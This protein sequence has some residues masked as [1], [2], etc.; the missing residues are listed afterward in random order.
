MAS[1]D[2]K[3][4]NGTDDML[5]SSTS[6]SID[7]S[8]MPMH[9]YP[10][11]STSQTVRLKRMQVKVAC[12]NCQKSCKKCDQARPCLRCVKYGF[13]PGECVDS[14]RKERKK[15]TK[16]GPYKK[17]DGQGNIIAQSKDPSFQELEIDLSSPSSNSAAP[18]GSIQPGHA[19]SFYPPSQGYKPGDPVY[20]QPQVYFP[21]PPNVGPEG[22][23]YPSTP[24]FFPATFPTVYAPPYSPY[25]PYVGPD[26]RVH[27][28][29]A[30]KPPAPTGSEEKDDKSEDLKN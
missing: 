28:P 8:V 10:F 1:S 5:D 6:E 29:P 14:Q 7:P 23:A 18:A 26:G 13:G 22:P 16:R 20:Y 17:R 9:M 19:P 11:P 24:Q 21:S 15:G 27:Y 25:M 2:E 30:V 12:T 4:L 3:N